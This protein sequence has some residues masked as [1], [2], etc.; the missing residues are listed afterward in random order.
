MDFVGKTEHIEEDWERFLESKRCSKAAKIPF[1]NE[2]G[3]HPTKSAQ[4]ERSRYT[5]FKCRI[6]VC[7]L[8]NAR[9]S[10]GT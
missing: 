2:L 1:S 3:Q 6:V 10:W 8:G 5:F 9:L 7:Y 4:A